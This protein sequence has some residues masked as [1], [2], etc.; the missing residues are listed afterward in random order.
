VVNLFSGLP[1]SFTEAYG[2][3]KT[4][5]VSIICR[6]IERRTIFWT[7]EDREDF[8][9]RL[10]VILQE[11]SAECYAWALLPNHFHLLLKPG[12]KSLSTIMQG[13]LTGFVGNVWG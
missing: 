5:F 10:D 3:V 11:T 4:L 13:L 9:E 12:N 8:V 6:G 2:F 1:R 7:D